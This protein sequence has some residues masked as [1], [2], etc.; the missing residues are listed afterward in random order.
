MV[1]EIVK[2]ANPTFTASIM[3][4]FCPKHQLEPCIFI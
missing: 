2:S 3:C 4:S 1:D